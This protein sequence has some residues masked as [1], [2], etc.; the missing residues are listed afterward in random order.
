MS[1]KESGS[2]STITRVSPAEVSVDKSVLR[3]EEQELP[4]PL[5]HI[6]VYYRRGAI[7]A[8]LMRLRRS[9]SQMKHDP[10]TLMVIADS[11]NKAEGWLYDDDRDG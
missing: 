6:A 5:E 2:V 1:P 7:V 11:N 4:A 9:A 3:A 8:K 10:F